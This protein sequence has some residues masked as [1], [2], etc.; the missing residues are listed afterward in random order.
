MGFF[1]TLFG[2]KPTSTTTVQSA[3]VT[4]PP[5]GNDNISLPAKQ[6]LDNYINLAAKVINNKG[7][8]NQK[9][10]V[11]LVLDVSG[12]MS[13]LYSNGFVQTLSERLLPLGV[14]FDDNQAIDVFLFSQNFCSLGE[15]TPDNFEDYIDKVAL[16]EGKSILWNGTS[17]API[18]RE[19][20]NKY[21]NEK[22]D[23]AY[24][25][26]VTDGDNDDHYET[27][28]VIKEASKVG[29]FWQYIGIGNASFSFLEKLD[30]MDGRF[31]DNAN[32][33]QANDI[34]RLSDN[35]LYERMLGE[36]PDWLKKAK[37]LNII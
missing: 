29:I 24:V 20:T 8:G 10:R 14:K 34:K 13:N 3:T 27:E 9:A 28:K 36:F 37:K 6:R 11:A 19:I 23:P 18:M 21:K 12:S 15:L 31:V 7:L 33:F 1:D 30:E 32:F 16:K 2:K 4:L 17:Y 25:M 35:D 5:K 22:G 26:F